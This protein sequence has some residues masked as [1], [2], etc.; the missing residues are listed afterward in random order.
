VTLRNRSSRQL[1]LRTSGPDDTR[2]LAATV[3][4]ALEVG[5]AVILTGELG[6]GKTTFVQGLAKAWGVRDDVTS[7]TYTIVS[8]YAAEA[9][10]VSMLVHVD[11]Y[12]LS[13][14]Q[15]ETDPAVR[16]VLARAGEPGRVTVIEW[17][18]KLE[19][20]SV[21]GAVRFKFH[22]GALP[23]ERVVRWSGVRL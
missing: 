21:P 18:D 22:H 7:P 16:D 2:Q 10:G 23:E 4:S 5:D 15:A 1:T 3:A 17:A 13:R 20:A 9:G 8:E 11:L 19:E 12:R 14:H 6:A